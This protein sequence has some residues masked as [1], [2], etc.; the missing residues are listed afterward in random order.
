MFDTTSMA[1]RAE[2]PFEITFVL[3][4]TNGALG[5]MPTDMCFDYNDCYECRNCNFARGSAEKIVGV[6]GQMLQTVKAD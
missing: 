4:Q 2:S 6:Y 3:S 1:V 5:Y